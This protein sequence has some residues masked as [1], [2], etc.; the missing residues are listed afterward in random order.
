MKNFLI[1]ISSLLFL[2]N[3]ALLAFTNGSG[4]ATDPY[5]IHNIDDLRLLADRVNTITD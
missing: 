3:A 4:T 1:A 5:Q 2:P